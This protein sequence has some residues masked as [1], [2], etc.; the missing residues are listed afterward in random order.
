MRANVGLG[1]RTTVGATVSDDDSTGADVGG[2][3]RGILGACVGPSVGNSV[4]RGVGSGV[5]KGVGS[6]VGKGV[7]KGVGRRVGV[8]VGKGV[9][10]S[11]GD[12]G[13]CVKPVTV[14]ILVG[15]VVGSALVGSTDGNPVTGEAVG[16]LTAQFLQVVRHD[17]ATSA[18]ES[19]S[20][21]ITAA[22]LPLTHPQF[23]DSSDT[24][25]N[26]SSLSG[27]QRASAGEDEGELVDTVSPGDATGAG[28]MNRSKSVKP[29][30]VLR[31]L[32]S[33]LL[34]ATTTDTI[35]TIK[36][37]TTKQALIIITREMLIPNSLVP[38]SSEAVTALERFDD[39]ICLDVR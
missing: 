1:V 17:F 37:I 23:T 39:P 34:L 35:T 19:H 33:S 32:S 28:V 10:G 22:S 20:T 38:S 2:S 15:F 27:G 26:K 3:G 16:S 31:V 7:G 13:Y 36:A 14:G 6:G 9:G 21:T 4:G 18:F 30:P 8:A 29:L 11:V 24:L 12:V 25:K 5:G